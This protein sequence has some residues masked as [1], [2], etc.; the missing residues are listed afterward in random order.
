MS[1]ELTG[2]NGN[3]KLTC[4]GIGEP[5]KALV[6]N[7]VGGLQYSNGGNVPSAQ[8]FGAY[9]GFG[10]SQTFGV[11]PVQYGP[12]LPA[13]PANPGVTNINARL[14]EVDSE[15]KMKCREAN[16]SS[17][18][19]GANLQTAVNGFV[20]VLTNAP[21]DQETIARLKGQLQEAKMN[22]IS[23]AQ[24]AATLQNQTV[25]ANQKIGDLTKQLESERAR[26]DKLEALYL[27]VTGKFEQLK[28]KTESQK[29]DSV[30]F[31]GF[32]RS[33]EDTDADT[34]SRNVR[35]RA[36]L[37]IESSAAGGYAAAGPAGFGSAAANQKTDVDEA[38]KK[39]FPGPA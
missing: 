11:I 25:A 3:A 27:D 10:A 7:R 19:R 30:T 12:P 15:G 16:I 6:A 31:G 14:T 4:I 18:A 39:Y 20:S 35:Q 22:A 33:F 9:Q 17:D 34:S 5:D 36:L 23:A 38:Y 13:S 24:Q 8:A 37:A 32:K 21:S 28:K 29:Q 26:A 2:T 1:F